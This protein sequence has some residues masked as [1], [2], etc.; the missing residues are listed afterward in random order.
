MIDNHF[1]K[2][3]PDYLR[4]LTGVLH[5]LGLSP[6]QI[7]VLGCALGIGAAVLIALGHFHSAIA[8][9]WL[10]RLFDAVDGIYARE[11]DKTS[12]FGAFLDIQLD[13]LAYS[14]MVVGFS[15]QF[16]EL[17]LNW[18]GIMFCYVLCI[19]GALGLG[20]FESKLA[21]SRPALADDSG[22]GLRIAAG[23]AEGGETGIAYTLFLLFPLY[24]E[25]LT[26]L[27]LAILVTTILARLRLAKNELQE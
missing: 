4:W 22:R 26:W 10:S 27:W 20:S 12:D 6:N 15:L 24:L 2:L 21:A 5:R 19:S 18:L 8:V 1:R 25:T 17:A 7:S 13:M 14:A 3:L 16:P 11:Y 9:W 23:L